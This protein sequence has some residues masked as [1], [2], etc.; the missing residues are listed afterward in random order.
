MWNI[1]QSWSPRQKDSL[2]PSII[3]L[4][5]ELLKGPNLGGDGQ[6]QQQESDAGVS[7]HVQEIMEGIFWF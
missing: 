3:L 1:I 6:S 7:S 4:T 5:N 2:H